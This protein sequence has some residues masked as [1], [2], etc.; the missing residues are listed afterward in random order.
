MK[1]I[2][3]LAVAMLLVFDFAFLMSS[4]SS[5]SE[6]TI[7]CLI[8]SLIFSAGCVGIIFAILAKQ[9]QKQHL[10]ARLPN[11]QNALTE[12][13]LFPPINLASVKV[14]PSQISQNKLFWG[15]SFLEGKHFVA[16][17]LYAQQSQL[18]E[19]EGIL[20]SIMHL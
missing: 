5:K 17:I 20:S 6:A 9:E 19:G 2:S 4:F 18:V 11:A 8:S 12:R 7:L 14:G 16:S 13:F 3:I 1:T 15:L 10:G